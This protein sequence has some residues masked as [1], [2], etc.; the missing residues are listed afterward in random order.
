[1]TKK[2]ITMGAKIIASVI[3]FM[4]AFFISITL[5]PFVIGYKPVVVLS[6]SMEPTYPIG[7]MIYYKSLDFADIKEGDAI[8]F[9]LGG[10]TLV[11]HR[12]IQKDDEKQVFTTKGDNNETVDTEPVPY[13][14][15]VGR[16]GKIII[17]YV[18]FIASHIK[19]IPI[20]I[21]LG[22]VLII[23]SILSP[24]KEKVRK[25]ICEEEKDNYTSD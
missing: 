4:I 20:V 19:E 6:G 25:S 7:S 21:T 24:T 13:Q 2:V 15:V 18:G 1:M 3:Y 22:M 17:P 9:R 11:T 10:G 14:T 8:T 5:I 16:T 12:V 23:C